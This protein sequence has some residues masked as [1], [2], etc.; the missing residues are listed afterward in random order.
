[1]ANRGSG[2]PYVIGLTGSIAMGKSETARLFAE[3]GIAV[4]DADATIHRLYGRG[5]AAVAEIAKMFPD[6]VREGAVDRVPLS[7]RVA[8]DAEA[9]RKLEGV[10]ASAGARRAG[11]L[12]SPSASPRR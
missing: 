2:K 1:M 4:H 11:F 5:G 9:L 6:A 12:S 10:D 8:G 3:E 7:K